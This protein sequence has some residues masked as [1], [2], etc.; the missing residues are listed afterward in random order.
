M[1]WLGAV[2][3]VYLIAPVVVFLVQ[4]P[5]GARE[6]APGLGSAAV[7]SLE[8]ATI[9]TAAVAVFGIPL[10]YVLARGRGRT[11][12]ALGVALQLPLA[13]PPLVSGILLLHLVGPYTAVGEFFGSNLTDNLIGIVLSQLFVSA[14]F[15]IIAARSAFSVVDPAWDDAAATLGHGSWARFRLVALPVA[16]PGIVA[17]LLLCWL[18]AFGEF[19]ANVILAYHPYS[20]PVFSFVQFGSTGLAGTQWPVLLIV[21]V[22][23]VV[24][25]GATVAPALLRRVPLP[26]HRAQ[27]REAEPVP[28]RASQPL[29]MSLHATQGDFRLD[30]DSSEGS[31]RLAVLGPSGAGKTFA[32]RIMAGLSA[33]GQVHVGD[34]DLSGLRPEDRRVVLMPQDSQLLPHLRVARQVTFG[35]GADP[36][37]AER[38]LHRLGLGGLHDRF[39][40]E[41]SGGQRRRVALIRSVA[42]HPRM[43]LL[44]EPCTGLDA[45]VR[46]ELTTQLRALQRDTGIGTVLVTHDPS[47]A[48]RLS[49]TVLVIEAGRLLQAGPTAEVF[50]HPTSATVARLVG[51]RNLG[52][53]MCGHPTIDAAL[54]ARGD[55]T[56]GVRITD[57]EV[58]VSAGARCR[59]IDSWPGGTGWE[60]E[61]GLGQ[62]S[63]VG[64]CRQRPA[65]GDA[66]AVSVADV[67]SWRS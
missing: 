47:E 64:L 6:S 57:V 8:T 51:V 20:L 17:G 3:L 67:M 45:A 52:A 4:F 16:L 46:D 37:V 58:T 31:D 9:T 27:P 48:A 34:L 7:V 23:L 2:L 33:G 59:V 50:A 21:V 54:R 35:V 22:A 29:S 38:W 55:H 49:D 11:S 26:A 24:L 65:P 28:H 32:L 15:A 56:W 18:R 44:D 19:G 40:A 25:G 14:P 53:G 62:A 5:G 13:F 10:A 61:V 43:L 30:L 42:V 66:C 36:D 41:L 1:P 12:T 39:P 60:C 63:I